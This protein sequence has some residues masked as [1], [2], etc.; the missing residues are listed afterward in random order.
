M[1]TYSVRVAI[2]YAVEVEADSPDE[3]GQ[4]YNDSSSDYSL[5]DVIDAE[6]VAVVAADSMFWDTDDLRS[7][8]KCDG[9]GKKL[10]PNSTGGRVQCVDCWLDERRALRA[11]TS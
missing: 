11:G 6:V 4:L 10:S 5:D 2:T 9:C 3:A 8:A 7:P 1:P